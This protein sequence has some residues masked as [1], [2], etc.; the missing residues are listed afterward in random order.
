VK[1]NSVPFP[2]GELGENAEPNADPGG[3][4]PVEEADDQELVNL[5]H[6]EEPKTHKQAMASPDA[7]EW[8]A[9]E[10]YELDQLACLDTYELTPLSHDRSCTG[11]RW[12]YKIKR[13]SKGDIVLY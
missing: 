9:A 2:T 13:D 8:L 10:R 7:N 12:V 6:G 4:P 3:V 1:P 5:A 11:C